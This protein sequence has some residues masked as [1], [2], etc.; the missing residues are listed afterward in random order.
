MAQPSREWMPVGRVAGPFGV[1]GEAKVDL[2]TDF[3]DRFRDLASV[4]IGPERRVFTI[5]RCRRHQARVVLKLAGVDTPEAVDALRGQELAVPREQAVK[6]PPGHYYLDDLTGMEV[7]T[8]DGSRVGVI[9]DVI[10]TGSND[11][12]V[13][14]E[15]R[16]EI[17]IP[18]IKDAVK[19]I[20]AERRRVV[21]DPWVLQVPD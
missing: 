7:V 13:I 11:V 1:K 12:Y 14:G 18:A 6:L 20:D 3:P 21:I 15:G 19:E 9:R 8:E 5:E 16:G 10:Q 17:L 4:H 2:L